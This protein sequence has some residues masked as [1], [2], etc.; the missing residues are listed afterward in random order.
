MEYDN[1]SAGVID[2]VKSKFLYIEIKNYFLTIFSTFVHNINAWNWKF[3]FFF[4]AVVPTILLAIAIQP[5]SLKDGLFILNIYQPTLVSMYFSNF[6]HSELGHLSGNLMIYLIFIS[7]IFFL[8]D[9][10]KITK[11]SIPFIFG[12]LPFIIS[13]ISV[14]YLGT[15]D[16]PIPPSQG[17]SGIVAAI[18]GYGLFLFAK[19]TYAQFTKPVFE[20]WDENKPV[21]KI[22]GIV[23]FLLVAYIIILILGFGFNFGLFSAEGGAL[24]NGIAHFTG[25]IF[26]IFFPLVIGLYYRR[27]DYP[28]YFVFLVGIVSILYQYFQYLLMFPTLIV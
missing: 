14:I 8:E 12:V 16:R 27:T 21:Q 20:N 7:V 24:A 1:I 26:G 10:P 6:T 15:I 13:V 4:Y 25:F 2:S 23:E 22:G 5:Q 18:M 9:N 17:F 19:W 3:W 28:F 11:L